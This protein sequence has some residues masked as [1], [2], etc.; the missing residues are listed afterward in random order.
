MMD[1]ALSLQMASVLAP[2]LPYIIGPYA[3]DPNMGKRLAVEKLG[4]KAVDHLWD[5]AIVVWGK[6]QPVTKDRPWALENLQLAAL[7][8]SKDP[9]SEMILSWE[10]ERLLPFLSTDTIQ[11]IKDILTEK[12]KRT[13]PTIASSRSV[14]FG[15]SV[16]GRAV[17]TADR[18][19]SRESMKKSG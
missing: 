7:K 4:Y 9:K 2:T 15:S 19:M 3:S 6:L 13:R 10:L 18:P 11:E 17:G 8:A 16:A 14:A 1:E 5:K 12:E